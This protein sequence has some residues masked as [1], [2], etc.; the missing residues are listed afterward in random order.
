M[1]RARAA[2]V[3]KGFWEAVDLGYGRIEMTHKSKEVN[4]KTLKFLFLE[5]KREDDMGA[6]TTAHKA[7]ECATCTF[8]LLLAPCV[9]VIVVFL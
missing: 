2:F 9:S 6:C 5:Q 3:Q 4:N 8:H 1:A 7:L